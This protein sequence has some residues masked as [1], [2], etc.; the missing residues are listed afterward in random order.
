MLAV[1]R[2]SRQPF[3]CSAGTLYAAAAELWD[4][5]AMAYYYQCLSGFGLCEAGEEGQLGIFVKG[6][7]RFVEQDDAPVPEKSPGD[8]NPLRLSFAEPASGL[9]A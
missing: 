9:S 1:G 5:P 6:G 7:G 3:S 8:C 4:C 2:L